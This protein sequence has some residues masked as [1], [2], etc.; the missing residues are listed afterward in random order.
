MAMLMLDDAF[1]FNLLMDD[2]SVASGRSSELS[3]GSSDG[4]QSPCVGRKRTHEEV[5]EERNGR[6][7]KSSSRIHIPRMNIRKRVT[8]MFVNVLNTWDGLLLARFLKRYAR[9]DV[10]FISYTDRLKP[11]YSTPMLT[12]VKGCANIVNYA[13]SFALCVPDA[14][15][16]LKSTEIRMNA[17]RSVIISE[18][19]FEGTVLLQPQ[20]RAVDLRCA[21][22]LEQGNS[23]VQGDN[24]LTAVGPQAAELN[25]ILASNADCFSW[26]A[27]LVALPAA[28]PYRRNGFLILKLDSND[29]IE[30]I[31][32]VDAFDS[33]VDYYLPLKDAVYSQFKR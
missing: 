5:R 23:V 18:I 6:R 19:T 14:C 25:R 4:A 30:S 9:E 26:F 2:C 17:G 11:L 31:D 10:T 33:I 15:M 20:P 16:Q 12:M 7:R 24:G 8:A 32:I 13:A 27:D 28:V 21:S 22:L 3:S 29:L 1:W